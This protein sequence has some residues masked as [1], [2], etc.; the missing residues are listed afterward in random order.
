MIKEK[1]VIEEKVVTEDKVETEDKEVREDKEV[2][3][4]KAETEEIEDKVGIKDRDVR[5]K[6]KT[7]AV[8]EEEVA[9]EMND[10]KN[11]IEMQMF[12]VVN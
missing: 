9:A 10:F 12:K 4:E 7:E 8:R 11:F 3:E 6:V 5:D 1:V 2:T